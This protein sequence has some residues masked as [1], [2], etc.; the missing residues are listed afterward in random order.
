MNKNPE[1]DG[2]R[3][4]QIPLQL[5]I[6][7]NELLRLDKVC[8]VLK[9]RLISASDQTPPEDTAK[10]D[11]PTLVPIAEELRNNNSTISHVSYQLEG[12]IDRLEL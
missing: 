4:R 8:S 12:M 10:G 7:K 6:Q 3:Q 1:V 2:K 9:D 5:E 11:Q